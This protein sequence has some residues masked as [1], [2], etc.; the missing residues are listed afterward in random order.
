MPNLPKVVRD[1]LAG[2]PAPANH[3]DP[4]LLTAFVEGAISGRERD[5]VLTHLAAC[6]ECRDVV[7]LAAPEFLADEKLVAASPQ[8][9]R[10]WA[11]PMLRWAALSVAVVVVLA[12]GLMVRPF[13]T[14]HDAR[15]ASDKA[16]LGPES[17][18]DSAPAA[19][20]ASKLSEKKQVFDYLASASEQK[21]MVAKRA[22][23]G[24]RDKLEA[25]RGIEPKPRPASPAASP[26][27]NAMVIAGN[28]L[29]MAR[30]EAAGR[31]KNAAPSPS[32]NAAA[33]PGSPGFVAHAA[34]AGAGLTTSEVVT[35]GTGALDV[36]S[37]QVQA[38]SEK[39]EMQTAR[40][41][42]GNERKKKDE[43]AL[44]KVAD[45]KSPAATDAMNS[46]PPASQTV[47]V[48]GAGVGP[49]RAAGIGGTTV[50]GRPAV[51]LMATPTS[52]P[53]AKL[54]PVRWTID[55]SGNLQRSNDLGKSWQFVPLADGAHLQ[56]LAVLQN[57]LWAGGAGGALYHSSDGG[58]HWTRVRPSAGDVALS[59]DVTRISLPDAL[60][61]TVTTSSSEVWSSADGGQT[62][63]KNSP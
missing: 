43:L 19:N 51:E 41:K 28:A 14:Y 37:A 44:A 45:T 8:P 12:V 53:Q 35:T 48:T 27:A 1:R 22:P 30:S 55:A 49:G 38:K 15:V 58:G 5:G 6:A 21:T 34:G 11:L 50:A 57:N 25:I 32:P 9:R 23:V 4:D 46:A 26:P 39:M 40:A 61:V 47:E 52:I 31:A 18:S 33:Q 54:P 16:A 20:A 3:P 60:H 7:S 10:F 63:R 13:R 62:W 29:S 42:A 24:D 59:D 17:R 36:E 56:A 2:A